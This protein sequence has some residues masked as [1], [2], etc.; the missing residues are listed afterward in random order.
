M[1]ENGMFSNQSV[2]L[3][4]LPKIEKATFIKVSPTYAKSKKI[5]YLVAIIFL[6]LTL[7]AFKQQ[8][9][10]EI[11]QKKEVYINFL[12]YFFF[13]VMIVLF[14][15]KSL[16]DVKKYYCIREKDISYK[17]GLIFT[18]TITQPMSRVQRIELIQGP[19]DK[20]IGLAKIQIFC[21]G[22]SISDMQIPGLLVEQ[23]EKIIHFIIEYKMQ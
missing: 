2:N 17:S 12:L 5:I 18:T 22:S 8:N 6:S 9:I 15:L 10:L 19:I 4:H 21:A 13:T 20:K 1:N 23:A 3:R 14:F 11:P 7:I 16:S